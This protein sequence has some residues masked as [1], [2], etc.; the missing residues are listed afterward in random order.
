MSIPYFLHP[1]RDAVV[2]PVA[3]LVDESAR[4]RSFEWR[5]FMRARTDDNRADLGEADAQI[6]D[7]LIR[8]E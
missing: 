1:A 3:E 6:S 8:S 2:A 5:A 7:Y 4:Y